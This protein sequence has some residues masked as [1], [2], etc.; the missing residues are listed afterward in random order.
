MTMKRSNALFLICLASLS[1]GCIVSDKPLFPWGAYQVKTPIK[2]G[3]YLRQDILTYES[4]QENWSAEVTP[5]YIGLQGNTYDY[6]KEDK[7]I[8]HRFQMFGSSKNKADYIAQ[9][10]Y[11]K[12]QWA[13]QYVNVADEGSFSTSEQRCS[14]VSPSHLEGLRQRGQ[15]TK[16]EKGEC[17]INHAEA[18]ILA[19]QM[20]GFF[21]RAK[22][23]IFIRTPDKSLMDFSE[24]AAP[25][26]TLNNCK[27]SYYPVQTFDPAFSGKNNAAQGLRRHVLTTSQESGT[28]VQYGVSLDAE[29]ERAGQWAYVGIHDE[30]TSEAACHAIHVIRVTALLPAKVGDLSGTQTA[31]QIQAVCSS[32][33][34]T[35]GTCGT[36][37][38]MLANSQGDVLLQGEELHRY[39]GGAVSLGHTLTVIGKRGLGPLTVLT[40]AKTGVTRVLIRK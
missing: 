36:F 3:W 1:S 13:Y 6:Y 12:T 10:Q 7:K 22:V 32:T 21:P 17:H 2:A 8:E 14:H 24:I 40:T 29:G 26:R 11:G 31:A 25:P 37:R 18:A 23:S 28:T 38:Q 15:L 27:D 34:A 16:F 30:R 33:T 4:G 19:T 9:S 35:A 20:P 39:P 5:V